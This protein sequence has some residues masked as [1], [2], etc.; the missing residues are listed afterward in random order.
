M[1]VEKLTRVSRL[2]LCCGF[3][4]TLSTIL[5]GSWKRHFELKK[6][7][8]S[9]KWCFQLQNVVETIVEN[10]GFSPSVISNMYHGIEGLKVVCYQCVQF[11]DIVEGNHPK[12][13]NVAMK[14][15]IHYNGYKTWS[16]FSI[17]W[18]IE[19]WKQ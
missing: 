17:T 8:Y 1:L 16:M 11:Y 7:F 5:V 18:T 3:D 14:W 15:W 19:K 13:I 9:W 2:W 12:R 4:S 6:T 10:L